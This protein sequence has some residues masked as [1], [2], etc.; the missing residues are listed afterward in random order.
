MKE[1]LQ[2]LKKTS[3]AQVI[4]IALT[5]VGFGIA[6]AR[7]EYQFDTRVDEIKDLVEQ[8][9]IKAEGKEALFTE[10]LRNLE[11]KV[12][13]GISTANMISEFLRPD[14]VQIRRRR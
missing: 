1:M 9:I 13:D 5:L 3:P 10:K 2:S 11:S 8:H 7:M 6:I 14:D 4:Q 12:N